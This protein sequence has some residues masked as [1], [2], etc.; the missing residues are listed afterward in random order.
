LP[1]EDGSI[2]PRLV[3]QISAR[4]R[5]LPGA[6]DLK[7]VID[8]TRQ[9]YEKVIQQ[10]PRWWATALL[11][12]SYA[13]LCGM[14]LLG[15]G[16]VLNAKQ[17]RLVSS[18]SPDFV[19]KLAAQMDTDGTNTVM[20]GVVLHPTN[21]PVPGLQF[22]LVLP[23]PTT[24][25]FAMTHGEF[26]ELNRRAADAF[27]PDLRQTFVVPVWSILPTTR[28]NVVPFTAAILGTN[29]V[30]AH[31]TNMIAGDFTSDAPGHWIVAKIFFDEYEFYLALNPVESIGMISR[32][33][34]ENG[35]EIIAEFSKLFDGKGVRKRAK[36]DLR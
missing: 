14:A 27:L 9:T 28:T 34:P 15:W 13:G 26:R 33:E 31:G 24:N 22:T 11:F 8:L 30:H 21:A 3:Q 5:E 20:R 23:P 25:F 4:V 1:P 6:N 29:L 19:F 35:P 17:G 7:N 2:A 32:K 16:I 10:P 12:I 36:K 18:D